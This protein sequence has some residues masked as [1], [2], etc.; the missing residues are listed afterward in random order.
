M[1][2]VF[3][4][5]AGKPLDPTHLHFSCHAACPHTHRLRVRLVEG[6]GWM[7]YG[8]PV[9]CEFGRHVLRLGEVC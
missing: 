7:G 6:R 5:R 8:R 4:G 1:D 9:F 3:S 2:C